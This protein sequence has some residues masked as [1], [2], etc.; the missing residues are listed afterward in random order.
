MRVRPVFFFLILVLFWGFQAG[1]ATPE[2]SPAQIMELI[3]QG[4]T[5]EAEEELK[6]VEQAEQRPPDLDEA[7][8]A[9][10]K[11]YLRE[12]RF[13]EAANAFDRI[14]A[15]AGVGLKAAFLARESRRGDG[16]R[17]D[18]PWVPAGLS[19][20]LPGLGQLYLGRRRDA[21]WALGLTPAPTVLAVAGIWAGSTLLFVP[22]GLVAL[23]FYGGAVYNA[24]NQAHKGNRK[25]MD[26]FVTE[27][28]NKAAALP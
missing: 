11:A 3:D 20:L 14:P 15:R 13:Q 22:A 18:S 12:Y 21:A 9:L 27:L 5:Q 4:R 17:Q 6:G 16:I 26:Q 1:A 24:L 19:L 8:Y 10:G 25:R 7:W 28:L 23:A 2:G